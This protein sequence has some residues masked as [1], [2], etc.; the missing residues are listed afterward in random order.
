MAVTPASG[1]GKDRYEVSY[2]KVSFIWLRFVQGY[3]RVV[4]DAWYDRLEERWSEDHPDLELASSMIA[5]RLS[6][7]ALLLAR[8]QDRLF[9]HFGLSRGEV[10]LLGALSAAGPGSRLTPTTLMRRLVLSS[11]G[12][13]S[14]LD[15]L[16]R[17]G[18]VRRL[19]DPSDR[20]GVLVELTTEGE[21]VLRDAVRANA[22][23]S[24]RFLSPLTQSERAM[25]DRAFRKLLEAV[26]PMGE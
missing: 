7:L 11:G 4:G 22:D 18:F 5:G 26:E 1:P 8:R 6:R 25:L 23:D 12:V 19:P 20:R 3:A 13:T 9:G 24:R 14:R 15:R 2:S 21:R 16:E 10:G 17:S